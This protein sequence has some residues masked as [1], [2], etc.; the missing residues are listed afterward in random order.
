MDAETLNLQLSTQPITEIPD[1]SARIWRYM[2]FAK[3]VSMLQNEAL[4][5]PVVAELGDELEAASPRL[6]GDATALEQAHA[7]SN[8]SLAR[9]IHFASCWHLADGE[10][11]AMWSLYAGRHQGIAVQSSLMALSSAFPVADQ[12][13]TRKIVKIG[14]VQYID[15]ARE[16]SPQLFSNL[17]R[18]VLRKR[19]WYRY[20]NE[21]RLICSPPDNWVEPV[22]VDQ[23]GGFERSGIWVRCNL[24]EMIQSV[25]VAPMAPPYLLPAVTE[26]F[27]RFGFDP[28]IVKTSELVE[29]VTPPDM[30]AY[31]AEMNALCEA[32]QRES[33]A[34]DE[35]AV[36]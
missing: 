25:V 20:E 19:E 16:E 4:Y 30:R 26:V 27:K 1:W 6:P 2:D 24:R 18:Q 31:R 9:C 3:F 28:A 14:I 7:F 33:R 10:S 29:R 34:W 21:M 8:W 36:R 23:P 15:P 13:D 11:A 32:A 5:F 22:S 35:E 17:Y 12:E